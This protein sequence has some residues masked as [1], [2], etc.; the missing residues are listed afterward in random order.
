M[1]Y[2]SLHWIA[3][4]SLTFLVGCSKQGAV[5]IQFLAG[6]KPVLQAQKGDV[7]KWVGP[8]GNPL[9][10]NFPVSSP[11]QEGSMTSTCTPRLPGLFPYDCT[12]CSDPGL[13]VGTTTFEVPS[14]LKMAPNTIAS[15]QLGYISCD[16]ATKVAKVYTDPLPAPPSTP[17]GDSTVQW[18]KV[19]DSGIT[20]FTI[21]LQPGTCKEGTIDQSQEVCTLVAGAASQTYTITADA[22]SPGTARLTIR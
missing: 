1:R 9:V 18:K 6:G 7:V 14:G 8:D 2:P 4:V 5:T 22:C 15:A 10:V 3:A 20:K 17:G 21:G 11:C 16:K 19:G 13:V 12:G